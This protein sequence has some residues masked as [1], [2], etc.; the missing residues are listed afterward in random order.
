MAMF[1]SLENRWEIKEILCT[2]IR[3]RWLYVS[4]SSQRNEMWMVSNGIMPISVLPARQ[5]KTCKG[6]IWRYQSR[7]WIVWWEVEWRILLILINFHCDPTHGYVLQR[8]SSESY[9]YYTVYGGLGR[10][11]SMGVF[12]DAALQTAFRILSTYSLCSIFI[13]SRVYTYDK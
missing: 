4:T 11:D 5:P 12:F 2:W 13:Q 9:V 6:F 10:R 7:T 1:S 3:W 8:F